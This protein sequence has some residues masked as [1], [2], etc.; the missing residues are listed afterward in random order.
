MAQIKINNIIYGSNNASDIIYKNITVEEKLD[1]IPIFDINDNGAIVVESDILTYGHI[2]DNLNSTESNKTLSAKQGKVL[3]EKINNI[4]FSSLEMAIGKNETAIENLNEELNSFEK[5]VNDLNNKIT[6]NTNNISSLADMNNIHLNLTLDE[7]TPLAVCRYLR[8]NINK[9]KF[10]LNG[11]HFN[12][13]VNNTDY[14]SGYIYGDNYNSYWGLLEQRTGSPNTHSFYKYFSMDGADTVTPFKNN[15]Y[16]FSLDFSKLKYDE[17]S[18]LIQ[19]PS[20][21]FSIIDDYALYNNSSYSK[22]ASTS[23]TYE[24]ICTPPTG[25]AK[26]LYSFGGSNS[27]GGVIVVGASNF[28]LYANGYIADISYTTSLNTNDKYHIAIVMTTSNTKLYINN[29]LI[30]TYNAGTAAMRTSTSFVIGYNESA[31][32]VENWSGGKMYKMIITQ[33]ALTPDTFKLSL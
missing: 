26:I 8:D 29:S 1:T 24:M 10:A 25:K 12:A 33:D 14:F 9:E 22:V 4:D 27:A 32:S 19:Y 16:F 6:T 20:S 30:G 5:E 21:N 15:S 23:R 28:I 3:S 17:N 11:V 7:V 31:P 2:V 18:M 13:M